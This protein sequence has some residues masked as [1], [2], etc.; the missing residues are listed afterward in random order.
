MSGAI[1]IAIIGAGLWGNQHARVFNALSEVNLVA[2]CDRDIA[3]A[4]SFATEFGVPACYTDHRQMFAEAK[5]DAVSIAT[6]DFAHSEIILDALSAGFHV[7][8]EKPLA[9]NIEEAERVARAAELSDRILMVDFHNRVNPAIEKAAAEIAAGRIGKLVHGSAR[10]S[11]TSFVP[12][13]MLGWAE[14]SS[15][16]WFLGSHLIDALRFITGQEIVEVFARRRDGVLSSRGI[17][18]A[19]VH[20]ALLTFED[21]IVIS[22]ENSWV[23]SPDNPQVFDF[24]IELVGDRGQID[25]NPSHNGAFARLGGDG[26]KYEDLFGITPAGSGRVGGFVQESIARFIDA[27]LLGVA[28]LATVEDGLRATQVLSAIEESA[29]TGQPRTLT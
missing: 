19:D 5:L 15:A 26:L 11:N 28:P 17:N 24:R 23:L 7:L 22:I 18:T 16:L 4:K 27:L 8:T 29:R 2:V 14:R 6:P 21:G 3:R 25:L 20:L 13:E 1:N 9:T 12:L 10:L